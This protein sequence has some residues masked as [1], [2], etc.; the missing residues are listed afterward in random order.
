MCHSSSDSLHVCMEW[1]EHD[2]SLGEI[3]AP[4]LL[5]SSA[6]QCPPHFW[7]SLQTRIFSPKKCMCVRMMNVILKLLLAFLTYFYHTLWIHSKKKGFDLDLNLQFMTLIL[8]WANSFPTLHFSPHLS[9]AVAHTTRANWD[10]SV[11][12]SALSYY[13][14]GR[15]GWWRVFARRKPSLCP[16]LNLSPS[17]LLEKVKQSLRKSL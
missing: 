6:P 5:L 3:Y 15:W 10:T 1:S 13:V 11:S 14:R 17:S 2:L 12:H 7:E 9:D 8:L 4:C 16:A